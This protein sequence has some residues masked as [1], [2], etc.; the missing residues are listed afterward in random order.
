MGEACTQGPWHN[1]VATTGL[2]ASWFH[3]LKLSGL[4]ILL[5]GIILPGIYGPLAAGQG[6]HESQGVWGTGGKGR[7]WLFHVT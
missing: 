6:D 3:H 5:Q 1:S 7:R 2:L 4:G